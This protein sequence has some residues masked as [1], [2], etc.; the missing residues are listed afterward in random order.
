MKRFT[1]PG[2]IVALCVGL[3]SV[4]YAD[5]KV[6]AD[7]GL[8]FWNYS[9]ADQELK[10]SMHLHSRLSEC[11]EQMRWRSELR[12]SL[13]EDLLARRATPEQTLRQFQELNR[14]STMSS[15][16]LWALYGTD[17]ERYIAGR[18]LGRYL[19][20]FVRIDARHRAIRDEV[21]CLLRS[22]FPG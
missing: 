3:V 1:R 16:L 4:A 13:I 17:D 22:E 2:L 15:E 6:A 18:Q 8:D 10:E 19:E 21:E 12:A 5:P 14:S 20:N 7:W 9:K 11:H